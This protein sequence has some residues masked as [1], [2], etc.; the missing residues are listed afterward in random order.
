M[1]RPKTI[2]DD[3]VLRIARDV[4][5]AHGHTATTREVAQAVG[6]IDDPDHRPAARRVRCIAMFGA[7][8]TPS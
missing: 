3:A 4:F 8:V 5:R 6:I 1:G 2:S 7:T